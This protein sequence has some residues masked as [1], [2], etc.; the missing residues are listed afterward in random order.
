MRR[1]GGPE[2]LL[3]RRR[4]VTTLAEHHGQK[5]R[6]IRGR[7]ERPYLSPQ[8][9]APL[10]QRTVEAEALRPMLQAQPLRIAHSPYDINALPA[11][12][13]LEIKTSR[14]VGTPHLTQTQTGHTHDI[15]G[16][17]WQ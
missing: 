9:L 4:E 10:F 12:E 2:A 7:Q 13:A 5:N 1:A 14:V 16:K 17:E 8:V 3:H 6:V 11:H 15:T